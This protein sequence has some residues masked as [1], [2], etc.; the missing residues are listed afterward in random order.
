MTKQL[1]LTLAP[2]KPPCDHRF[3]FI[4]QLYTPPQPVCTKCGIVLTEIP[5]PQ[6]KTGNPA[7]NSHNPAP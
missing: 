2:A 6:N 1:L 3:T 7:E 4:S 5:S